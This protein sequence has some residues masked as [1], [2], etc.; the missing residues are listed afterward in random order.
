MSGAKGG[1]HMKECAAFFSDDVELE[2]GVDK[3]AAIAI[4]Q[5][6][7]VGRG[8]AQPPGASFPRRSE[9]RD[10]RLAG[11]SQEQIARPLPLL[12]RCCT[13]ICPAA[14]LLSL[15]LLPVQLHAFFWRARSL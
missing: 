5:R 11:P 7:G 10:S 3:L 15:L 13:R 14:K 9:V 2:T 4:A 12:R 6:Q 8:L 1:I